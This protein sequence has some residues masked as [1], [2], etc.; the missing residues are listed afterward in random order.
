MA[1]IP[2]GC[3]PWPT[4]KEL[5]TQEYFR[6]N[7]GMLVKHNAILKIEQYPNGCHLTLQPDHKTETIVARERGE[8]LG[9]GWEVNKFYF[10]GIPI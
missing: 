10:E 8:S 3:H 5:P 9:I 4:P 1:K 2:L 7:R 6:I